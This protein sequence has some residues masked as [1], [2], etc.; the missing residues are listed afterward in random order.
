MSKRPTGETLT[1]VRA[2]SADAVVIVH[3]APFVDYLRRMIE[4][5]RGREF[6]RAIDIRVVKTTLDADRAL[7]GLRRP[8]VFDHAW[9]DFV[10]VH[11][12][13]YT[14][15]LADQVNTVWGRGVD[16]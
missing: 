7:M 10:P 13:R 4:A 14:R 11:V 12:E 1:M 3:G 5:E 9:R 15:A 6:A 2:L 8:V 16:S